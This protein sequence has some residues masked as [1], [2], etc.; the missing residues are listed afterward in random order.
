MENILDFIGQ[1]FG[2]ILFAAMVIITAAALIR[3]IIKMKKRKAINIT[4]VGVFN[5]LPESVTGI[6]KDKGWEIKEKSQPLDE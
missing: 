1:S 3:S 2:I 5:D 6:K 4:P